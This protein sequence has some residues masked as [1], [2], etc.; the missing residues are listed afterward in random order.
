M[1]IVVAAPGRAPV[2][3]IKEALIWARVRGIPVGT[4]EY[5]VACNSIGYPAR[6]E[7]DRLRDAVCP[8]GAVILMRQ[9]ACPHLPY[10][11]AEALGVHQA[12]VEGFAAGVDLQVAPAAWVKSA[13]RDLCLHGFQT[14]A[15]MRLYMSGRG[16]DKVAV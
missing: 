15:V 11:A 13:C 16:F 4:G 14:G 10:A 6:W 5:G 2:E 8:L 12:W 7:R 9:P 1:G 3:V